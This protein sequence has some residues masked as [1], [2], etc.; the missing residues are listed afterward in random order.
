MEPRVRYTKTEDGVK[1]AYW[2]VGDGP[3]LV[4]TPYQR[5]SHIGLEWQSEVYRRIYERLASNCTLI[6][7]D[8]R[9]VGLSQRDLLDF[10]VDAHTRDLAAIVGVVDEAPVAVLALGNWG[11]PAVRFAAENPVAVSKLVLYDSYISKSEST[12]IPMVAAFGAVG[13]VLTDRSLEQLGRTWGAMVGSDPEWEARY[14]TASITPAA[15][16]HDS[17]QTADCSLWVP[18]VQCPCLVIHEEWPG[19]TSQ[20]SATLAAALPDAQLV[21]VKRTVD[22]PWWDVADITSVVYE[23]LDLSPPLPHGQKR[24]VPQKPPDSSDVTI[25]AGAT[26]AKT[27][28]SGRYVVQH[29]LGEGAQK[30]VYLVHDEAL[31]RDCALSLIKAEMLDTEDLSRFRR[32]AQAMAALGAQVNV[33]T[34]F[35]IGEESGRP[36]LISEY[37]GGGDLRRE[38]REVGGRFDIDRAI[39]IASDV[40]HALGLAH[41]R[42]IIHRDIK[43]GN[44][45]LTDQGTAKL[46]DFGLAATMDQT[47]LTQAGTMMGTAAYMSPEQG[48]GGEIDARTDLYALG[49]VVYEMVTGRPPFVG[50][51][52]L[53][54]I[55]QH[56][57]TAPVAPSWHNPA[58]PPALDSLILRLLATSPTER[59]QSAATVLAELNKIREAGLQEPGVLGPKAS[60]L[61]GMAWGAFVGRK[62]EL[63]QLKSAL[64][65]TLSG[66]GSLVLIAGEPGIGKTRLAE[67]F[68][69][70]AS[71]RGACVLTG[72]CFEEA[73]APYGP[74]VEALRQYARG[75]EDDALREQMGEGAPEIATLVADVRRRLPEVG[76]ALSLE[77]EG[78]RLRL[79]ESVTTFVKNA[80]KARPLLVVV[81]DLHWA[82]KPSLLVLQYLL[83]GIADARVLVIGTYRD[84]DVD[85]DHPLAETLAALARQQNYRRVSLHGLSEGDVEELLLAIESSEEIRG[86]GQPLSATLYQETE[87]NPFF[88]HEVLSHLVEEGKLY[89]EGGR[90][91]STAID[92][93]E[94]SIPGS[95]REVIGRRLSHLSDACGSMLTTA[96]AMTGRF[97]WEELRAVSGDDEG[98]LLD[99]LDEALANQLIVERKKDQEGTYD[100]THALIRQSLYEVISTPRKVLLHGRIAE[101]LEELYAAEVETH[102]PTLAYHFSQ[103]ARGGSAD[104][105]IGYAVRAAE[106]ALAQAAFEEASQQSISVARNWAPFESAPPWHPSLTHTGRPTLAADLAHCRPILL[107][108]RSTQTLE[109]GTHTLAGSVHRYGIA[110]ADLG[111]DAIM[112]LPER[113][114]WRR[115]ST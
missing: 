46:G 41:E 81:E 84:V 95:V 88:M 77:A 66:Q 57:N 20:L 32:E 5:Y 109:P 30:V 114:W 59:P 108:S 34:V 13:D 91:R 54:V 87:G 40:A 68:A 49:A 92:G 70:Y 60:D 44:V 50:D 80:A 47:R 110:E 89:R 39:A 43:P 25:T 105:A 29:A 112:Q 107:D 98:A 75:I 82:D 101:A 45:W 3:P 23:F 99:L 28:A 78:E 10:S 48:L 61:Q 14:I 16:R 2:K 67:E 19:D 8:G 86:G 106:R 53:A 35:D 100:F 21:V 31:N 97:S 69:V 33:V 22:D 51:D 37:I 63:G 56:I 6:R 26:A 9:G 58:V 103:G 94:L 102:L 24:L 52:A 113:L 27:F 15:L 79:F 96:S 72:Q 1:I 93:S 83:R 17:H 64:E 12:N 18:H 62:E 55:S 65:K 74:F 73:S 111:F 104:K 7:F 11:P 85:R 76:E 71:L 90:W 42:G 4:M 38:L 115:P 36:F